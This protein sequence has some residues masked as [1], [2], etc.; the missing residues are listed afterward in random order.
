MNAGPRRSAAL[1]L[2]ASLLALVA[3]VGAIVVAVVLAAHT[4]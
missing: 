1:V 4:L 2:A 3:A